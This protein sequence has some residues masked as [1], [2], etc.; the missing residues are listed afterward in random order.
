MSKYFLTFGKILCIITG[1]STILKDCP[2]YLKF[3]M[4]HLSRWLQFNLMYL[5]KPPWDTGVSPP[6]LQEFI[7]THAPGHAID[8]GCGTGTNLLTL[9]KA[10]WLVTGVDFA[11]KA[12]RTARSR[13]ADEGF[14]GEVRAGDVSRLDV[15]QGSYELVLDIGCYHALGVEARAAYRSNLD[16]ILKPGGTFLIYGHWKATGDTDGPGITQA[17]Y[18]TLCAQLALVSHADGTDRGKRASVW[19]TFEHRSKAAAAG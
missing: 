6:E 14:P 11:I 13:L 2:Y 7:R 9:A 15:V 5:G 17:D 16:V 8:L 18:D 4:R 3:P 19:L 10:G 1:I 12:V